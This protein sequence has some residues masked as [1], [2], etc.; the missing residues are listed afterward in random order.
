M[1]NVPPGYTLIENAL[2]I[3]IVRKDYEDRLTK[4][5]IH[6]P[7]R[8][9]D[10]ALQDKKDL[11]LGRGAVPSIPIEGS[12]EEK[13][14]IR[15]Y[16]RGGF[17]RFLNHD[18]FW[19]LK[20]PLRELLITVEAFAKGIPTL[21]VLSAISIKTRGPFYRGYLITKEL[22]SFTDLAS[23]LT[24]LAS[25]S[26]KEM[27]FKKKDGILKSV[28]ET[29]NLMHDRGF[30]HGDLNLK[31]ILIDNL[32]PEKICIIDWDKSRSKER[33]TRS[34]KSANVRRF[35]R[36]MAK[37]SRYGLPL[38]EKDLM[39]FLETYWQGTETASQE[40]KRDL[41]R[42]RL[43]LALRSFFWKKLSK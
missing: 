28:A 35:C 27:F 33:L 37:L 40:V 12:L 21:E 2:S 19:G 30:Y 32:N 23:Y 34:E 38:T 36:S 26:S 6:N 17:I 24:A 31:N 41:Q 16:L 25:S 3:I 29:V 5:G 39:I 42:I 7:D 11:H 15:K 20:R 4:Q 1:I 8:L 22:S 13:M 9:I 10:L 14:V 43:S 18:V